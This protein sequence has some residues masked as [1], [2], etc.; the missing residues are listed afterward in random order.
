MMHCCCRM[1]L[2]GVYSEGVEGRRGGEYSC[3]RGRED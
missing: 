2:L 1:Q 3:R